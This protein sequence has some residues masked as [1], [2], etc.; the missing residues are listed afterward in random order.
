[1]SL[2][3]QAIARA[4]MLT[5]PVDLLGID[6]AF[7]VRIPCD[8]LTAHIRSVADSIKSAGYDRSMPLRV[9]LQNDKAIVVNGHCRLAAVKLAIS[10]GTD[11]RGIPCVIEPKGTTDADRDLALLT[12]NNGLLF[13]PLEQVIPVM[14]MLSHGW[15]K[16]D[17]A[18]KCGKSPQWVDNLLI[19]N[20]AAAPLREAVVNNEISATL[21]TSLAREGDQISV[22]K[23][24]AA[25]QSAPG[26]RVTAATIARSQPVVK[27]PRQQAID[28]V[29][30]AWDQINPR[31]IPAVLQGAIEDLRPFA[32][33]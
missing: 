22:S 31:D 19:L 18:D 24:L 20:G 33:K 7:N 32:T 30:D 29:M 9:R 28:D 13:Q 23:L 14:R 6:P 21:A 1:M 10:E 3:E 27:S 17:I 11:I 12:T 26:Q 5:L 8:A 4:D 25:K 16:K 15:T 2:K